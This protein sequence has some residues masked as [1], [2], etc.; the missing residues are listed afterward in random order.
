MDYGGDYRMDEIG[1]IKGGVLNCK[2]RENHSKRAQD[3]MNYNTLET[4]TFPTNW[5]TVN[6][7][8]DF[9]CLVKAAIV[10]QSDKL[11]N[12]CIKIK[13][14]PSAIYLISAII[15]Y[16]G[17]SKNFV[18]N[19]EFILPLNQLT[20][21]VA[22][23]NSSSH[24][25]YVKK[26]LFTLSK[27]SILGKPPV[28]SIESKRGYRPIIQFNNSLKEIQSFLSNS[29][30]DFVKISFK[31]VQNIISKLIDESR[32]MGYFL[33][34]VSLTQ[35]KIL[36]SRSLNNLALNQYVNLIDD[37]EKNKRS[38]NRLFSI[39]S[40]K[41]HHSIQEIKDKGLERLSK[42][43]N[44]NFKNEVDSIALETITDQEE[45]AFYR[46][47]VDNIKDSKVLD[48]STKNSSKGD[49]VRFEFVS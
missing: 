34:S 17:S 11:D 3:I 24:C 19:K 30:E 18:E 39:F 12:K 22:G 32:S 13:K 37:N 7:G 47:F 6:Y 26:I 40:P 8:L 38:D 48:I 25:D 20:S 43:L 14:V 33:E 35:K 9:A 41:G 27:I 46:K 45:Q 4:L 36:E 16:L 44:S 1:K 5:K 49:E 21:M 29:K 42:I 2:A 10:N 15:N 28:L 31:S 23:S